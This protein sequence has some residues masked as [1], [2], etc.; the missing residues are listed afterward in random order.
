MPKRKPGTGTVF[1]IKSKRKYMASFINP[2]GKRISHSFKTKK[3]AELFLA[4]QIYLLQNNKY[5]ADPDV[6]MTLARWLM[7]YLLTYKKPVVSIQTYRAYVEA[8]ERMEPI[9]NLKL[10]D[11]HNV[12]I[13]QDFF[14]SMLEK[15]STSTVALMKTVLCQAIH[16]AY[17]LQVISQ[18]Y[19]NQIELLQQRRK[20]STACVFSL[21]ELESL[22][23]FYKDL[24]DRQ[25]RG[26]QHYVIFMIALYTGMRVSE[27][28]ALSW[29]DINLKIGEIYVHKTLVSD[30]HKTI[31]QNV[32]KSMAG[33]RKIRIPAL[34][35]SL[36]QEYRLRWM[37]K[38]Y[39]TLI[40]FQSNVIKNQY[41]TLRSVD[42]LFLLACNSC[43]ISGR[44]FHGLR[45]TYASYL[46]L[47][48]VPLSVVSH[49]LGH[50]NSSIT[51]NI[52]SH[53]ING[54]DPVV[55]QVAEKMYSDTLK[56]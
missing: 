8:V 41:L 34:L 9:L 17:M 33:I 18:D 45:H 21:Q 31:L 19:S 12:F 10:K 56:P 26:W 15:Y 37:E 44:T 54:S 55:A 22:K 20:K 35:I 50:S 51:L 28:L 38:K 53:F 30:A 2:I 52:Y 49:T 6:K 16:K 40:L 14:N 27:I 29:T 25:A 39:E 1:Y 11:F 43:G 46:L 48:N 32:P 13:I 3:E 4:R 47:K 42:K 24:Y 23:S 36:L 7:Y 5:D